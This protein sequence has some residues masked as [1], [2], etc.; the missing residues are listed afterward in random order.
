VKQSP[1]CLSLSLVGSEQNKSTTP[2]AAC[3]L[4]HETSNPLPRHN[5]I[6]RT[7]CLTNCEAS[8]TPV[9][10]SQTNKCCC[11]ILAQGPNSVCEMVS[12]LGYNC[13]NE[14]LT[15]SMKKKTNIQLR[16]F[17]K[18]TYSLIGSCVAFDSVTIP[19]EPV[20]I[21]PF[22]FLDFHV[23]LNQ[24]CREREKLVVLVLLGLSWLCF[25]CLYL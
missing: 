20:F 1:A 15:T 10:T 9:K 25:Y 7:Q 23:N 4:S 24:K 14:S 22:F 5:P 12:G 17:K 3:A 16:I 8:Q 13:P 6:N 21:F 2:V 19:F 18:M 11:S